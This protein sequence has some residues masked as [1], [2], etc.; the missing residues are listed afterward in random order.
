M[1]LLYRSI[2]SSECFYDI[3]NFLRIA[4]HP[5]GIE[6]YFTVKMRLFLLNKLPIQHLFHH[7]TKLFFIIKNI[8]IIAKILVHSSQL[9][10]SPQKRG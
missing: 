9:F 7:L 10:Q 6:S 8:Y 2:I 3:Y 5:Q 1:Y 4:S